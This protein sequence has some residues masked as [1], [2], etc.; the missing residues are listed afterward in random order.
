MNFKT[1][2]V[3]INT[4]K[5]NKDPSDDEVNC[6]LS[7]L[8][9]VNQTG[10]P[11][12]I[13]ELKKCLDVLFEK[14]GKG[15]VSKNRLKRL[16]NQMK[17]EDKSL[18]QVMTTA[19]PCKISEKETDAL[20]E[21]KLEETKVG[22]VSETV[23]IHRPVPLKGKPELEQKEEKQVDDASLWHIEGSKLTNWGENSSDSVQNISIVPCSKKQSKQPSGGTPMKGVDEPALKAS[24]TPPPEP[25]LSYSS[26]STSSEFMAN[27]CAPDMNK[28]ESPLGSPSPQGTVHLQSATEEDVWSDQALI[29]LDE[30]TTKMHY[31]TEYSLMNTSILGSRHFSEPTQFKSSIEQDQLR[32]PL[33]KKQKLEATEVTSMK[34]EHE[35]KSTETTISEKQGEIQNERT[36]SLIHSKEAPELL[37]ALA[38]QEVT[39]PPATSCATE[40]KPTEPA[41][42]KEPLV[43]ASEERT[44][45]KRALKE[46]AARPQQRIDHEDTWKCPCTI[47]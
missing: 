22:A 14:Q 1:N 20:L 19:T 21:N 29:L 39:S 32:D 47:G 42:G 35:G 2:E 10:E 8:L 23:S 7:K 43:A 26:G 16:K 44:A 11:K 45:S 37:D 17:V 13:S 40:P 4:E 41:V 46:L 30:A 27:A 5:D 18:E 34:Q 33:K 25:C 12:S 3:M 6:L 24:M 38:E 9:T 36:A 15:K 31:A 28:K